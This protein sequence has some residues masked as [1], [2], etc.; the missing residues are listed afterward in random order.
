METLIKMK[1]D[2]FI[3]MKKVHSKKSKEDPAILFLGMYSK[4]LKTAS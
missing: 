4:E 1:R 2:T 3:K